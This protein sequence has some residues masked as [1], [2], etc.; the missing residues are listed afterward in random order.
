MK[1]FISFISN[2][3]CLRQLSAGGRFGAVVPFVLLHVAALGV[4]AVEW[5]PA[6]LWGFAAEGRS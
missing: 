1:T 6:M 3:G 2:T 4:V 5:S